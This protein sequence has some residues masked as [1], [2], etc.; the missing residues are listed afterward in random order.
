MLVGLGDRV[1][2]QAQHHVLRVRHRLDAGGVDR[3]HLFDQPEDARKLAERCSRFGVIDRD[4]G[5]MGDAFHIV[6]SQGHESL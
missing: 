4:P 6:E 1:V 3:L 5:Q 2:A